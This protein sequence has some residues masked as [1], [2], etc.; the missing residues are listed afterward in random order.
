MICSRTNAK[1]KA[2]FISFLEE[3]L[4]Y[5][6]FFFNSSKKVFKKFPKKTQKIL[7]LLI[8]LYLF[9]KPIE[10]KTKK[11]DDICIVRVGPFFKRAE[12]DAFRINN[13]KFHEIKDFKE[14]RIDLLN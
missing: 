5:I 14:N 9:L 3:K 11:K 13:K 6:I 8:F 12:T 7:T 4:I 10:E 2:R 1:Q